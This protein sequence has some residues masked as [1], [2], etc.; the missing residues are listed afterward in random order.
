MGITKMTQRADGITKK[1]IRFQRVRD[2]A[3]SALV[4]K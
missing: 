4:A 2:S 1:G 3:A